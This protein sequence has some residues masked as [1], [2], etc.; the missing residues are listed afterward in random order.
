MNKP[1]YTS[2]REQQLMQQLLESQQHAEQLDR[3][4]KFLRGKSEEAHLESKQL[5]KEFSDSVENVTALK[6]SNQEMTQELQALQLQFRELKNQVY[7]TQKERDQTK[8][9]LGDIQGKSVNLSHVEQELSAI[10]TTLAEGLKQAREIEQ[11]YL[12]AM[13]EKVA[14]VNESSQLIRQNDQLLEETRLLK[15]QLC[16]AHAREQEL[17][18]GIGQQ[19]D[20]LVR[21]RDRSLQ[22]VKEAQMSLDHL[23]RENAELKTKNK[24]LEE[25]TAR[26]ETHQREHDFEIRTAHQHL[27]KKVKETALLSEQVEELKIRLLEYQKAKENEKRLDEKLQ[28]SRRQ[29]EEQSSK[30]E[31]K[32]FKLCERLQEA[33]ARNKELHA[34]EEKHNQM[35]ALLANLG[36][37]MNRTQN[38]S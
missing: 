27:A 15:D 16:D 33:E 25:R 31:E 17:Q 37:F 30:W 23:K 6:T 35:Q 2:E 1:S 3:V 24:E 14:A 8:A 28:E 32:Y 18:A 7:T 34:L 20:Q 21:Q 38:P 12:N 36:N 22:H 29:F 10:K 5:E 4:I 11:Q 26:I 9:L 13:D 19:L